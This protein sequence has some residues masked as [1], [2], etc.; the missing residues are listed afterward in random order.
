M[1]YTCTVTLGQ[2]QRWAWNLVFVFVLCDSKWRNL[3]DIYR[4]QR[5]HKLNTKYVTE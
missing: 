4:T 5:L 2:S 1:L 3:L